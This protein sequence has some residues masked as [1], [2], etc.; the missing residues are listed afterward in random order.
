MERL[1]PVDLENA[2][3]PVVRKGYETGAVDALLHKAAHEIESQRR[4]IQV[5]KEECYSGAKELKRL[6]EQESLLSETLVLAQK[7]AED[8]KANAKKEA[9]LILEEARQRAK[10]VIREAEDQNQ[11]AFWDIQRLEQQKSSFENRFREILEEHLHQLRR[12][13]SGEDTARAA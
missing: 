4:E 1:D 10:E 12:P 7:T 5:L 2:Q 13:E 6:K 11:K 8:L 3:L 9:D